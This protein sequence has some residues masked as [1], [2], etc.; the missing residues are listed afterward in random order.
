MSQ[1]RRD[2]EALKQQIARSDLAERISGWGVDGRSVTIRV[3]PDKTFLTCTIFY[4]SESDY[5]SCPLMAMC[6]GDDK[7]NSILESFEDHFEFGAPVLEVV[8]KLL[9]EVGLDAGG[10]EPQPASE[11]ASEND[12]DID[13]EEDY[14]DTGQDMAE[15]DNQV[16]FC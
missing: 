15:T 5:P 9:E 14:S 1:L 12:E 6:T 8:I 16:D 11:A 4:M 7:V 10:L 3:K 13:S 2:V